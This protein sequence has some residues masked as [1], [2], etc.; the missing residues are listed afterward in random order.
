[1]SVSDV[2]LGIVRLGK[3]AGKTKYTIL[4]E[5]DISLV[6]QYAF[7]PR[8]EVDQDGNGAKV[9]A[10]AYKLS[11]GRTSARLV[12]NILWEKHRGGVA[13]GFKVEHKNGITVDNRLENL[14]LVRDT[15]CSDDEPQEGVS[16]SDPSL[17]YLAIQQLPND[18]IDEQFPGLMATH[19]YKSNGEMVSNDDE[20]QSFYECHYPPCTKIE[21]EFRGFSV[22]GHCQLVRY[23]G[24][25][26]QQKDWA[27]HKKH[28]RH[29]KQN[30]PRFCYSPER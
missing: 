15:N 4:D 23:C 14:C 2:K 16:G 22:C 17:Y 28:C 24:Y 21:R 30:L 11:K 29:K 3:A 12:H 7:E 27:A 19:F 25:T 6:E 9:Y 20:T 8:M 10:Y 18:P 13:Y 5:E 1:M 26:C